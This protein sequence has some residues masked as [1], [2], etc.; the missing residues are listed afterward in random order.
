[1]FPRVA[2]PR[3]RCIVW[4]ELGAVGLLSLLDPHPPP[5]TLVTVGGLQAQANDQGAPDDQPA[6]RGPSV[7]RI[8]DASDTRNTD[9]AIAAFAN[10]ATS[11]VPNANSGGCAVGRGEVVEGGD[12]ERWGWARA[13]LYPP[14]VDK[15]II[16]EY[17]TALQHPRFGPAVDGAGGGEAATVAVEEQESVTM[18]MRSVAIHHLACYFFPPPPSS[19]SSSKPSVSFS[20]QSADKNHLDCQSKPVRTSPIGHPATAGNSSSSSSARTKQIGGEAGD[21]QGEKIQSAH[22]FPSTS[23]GADFGRRKRFERLLLLGTGD[24]ARTVGGNSKGIANDS[25]GE[26][27][28]QRGRF[29]RSVAEAVLGHQCGG[30]HLA[31]AGSSL[32]LGLGGADGGRRR[33]S[34]EQEACRWGPK[35]GL[36]R[37]KVVQVYCERGTVRSSGL[38]DEDVVAWL[39]TEGELDVRDVVDSLRSGLNSCS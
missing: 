35:L 21:D 7:D 25:V 36:E 38:G 33:N 15:S 19:S 29:A 30:V 24:P 3:R 14:D 18:T 17:L 37:R 6:N 23:C 11:S 27:Q 34:H 9:A 8:V 32:V 10:S 39:E 22:V 16:D 5:N 26:D 1:M 2:R 31:S 4:K 13:Y 20:T 28:Q 12:G